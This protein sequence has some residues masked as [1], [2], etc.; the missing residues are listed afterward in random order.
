MALIIIKKR[1]APALPEPDELVVE[2]CCDFAGPPVPKTRDIDIGPGL[3]L[4]A[5]TLC[6]GLWRNKERQGLPAAR[7]PSWMHMD[8]KAR[9]AGTK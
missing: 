6:G 1:H 7:C 9:K 4:F 5:C 8:A 3:E 2:P